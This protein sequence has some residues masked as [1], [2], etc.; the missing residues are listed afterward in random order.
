VPEKSALIAALIIDRPMCADCIGT[1]ATLDAAE[2]E[3]YLSIMGRVLQIH[4]GDAECASCG[5]TKEVVSCS[6][7]LR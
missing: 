1:Q 4:R 3:A 6:L 5:A 7:F 2:V